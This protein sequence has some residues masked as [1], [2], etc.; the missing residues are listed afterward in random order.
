[1][2]ILITILKGIFCISALMLVAWVKLNF[3]LDRT[4]S[5]LTILSGTAFCVLLVATSWNVFTVTKLLFFISY[6]YFLYI[7]TDYKII[8]ALC[9]IPTILLA[10]QVTN[11]NLLDLIIIIISIVWVIG[12]LIHIFLISKDK[13]TYVTKT[14]K[15]LVA[16]TMITYII[17]SIIY[18]LNI[19]RCESVQTKKFTLVAINDNSSITG[20]FLFITEESTYNFY[21]KTADGSVRQDSIPLEDANLYIIENNQKAYLEKI[22]TSNYFSNNNIRPPA[23]CFEKSTIKY[24]LYI[25]EKTLYGNYNFD[26]E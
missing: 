24:N 5:I 8:D 16:I 1:M 21:Y 3:K 22:V 14:L 18:V 20:N 2:Q 19:E 7:Y 11:L 4:Y 9:I 25:T 26:A 15:F 17:T 13:N 12:I 10:Y 23:H 6:C